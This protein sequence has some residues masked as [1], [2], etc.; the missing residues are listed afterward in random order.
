M[1]SK[2]LPVASGAIYVRQYFN[3]E[4]KD[5]ATEMVDGIRKEFEN[6]LKSVSW[7]DDKTRSAAIS[8]LQKMQ[9]H[10]AY[11]S[12]LMDDKK[13]IEHYKD[14]DVSK[15]EFLRSAF[16]ANRFR[17]ESETKKFREIINKT[18][19]ESHSDVGIANAYYVWLENSIRELNNSQSSEL[20]LLSIS[21]PFSDSRRYSSRSVLCS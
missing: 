20:S 11:P 13:L 3:E 14:L 19:W 6:I 4:S 16:N 5:S 18:H 17:L 12:E 10:I 1:T 2:F 8:K 21:F 15:G 9:N 7:M